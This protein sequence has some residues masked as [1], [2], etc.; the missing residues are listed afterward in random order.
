MVVVVVG[1]VLVVPAVVAEVVVVDPSPFVT[2]RGAVV[3]DPRDACGGR[4]G[5][6]LYTLVQGQGQ[7]QQH[8]PQG[9]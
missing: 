8:E 4:D 3:R 6:L 7:R 1:V 2:A 5:L 9:L